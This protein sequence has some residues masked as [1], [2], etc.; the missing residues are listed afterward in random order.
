MGMDW[1]AAVAVVAT[2]GASDGDDDIVQRTGWIGTPMESRCVQYW[3]LPHRNCRTE[4]LITTLAEAVDR[5][6]AK[7]RGLVLPDLAP[8]LAAYP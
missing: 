3:I 7:D 6:R 5:A 4:D 2:I 8:A 1:K